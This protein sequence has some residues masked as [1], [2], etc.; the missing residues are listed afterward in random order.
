[1]TAI[2]ASPLWGDHHGYPGCAGC[3]MCL[4]C[5]LEDEQCPGCASLAVARAAA[6][7]PRPVDRDGAPRSTTGG[8]MGEADW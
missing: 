8:P 6:Q 1:M 4:G 7:P 2:P 5:V 3:Q